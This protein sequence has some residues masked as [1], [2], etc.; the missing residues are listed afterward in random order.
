MAGTMV[1]LLV[2]EK[3]LKELQRRNWRYPD[4]EES[5]F[6]PDYFIAG[7]IC[8]DGIMACKNYER[9]MKLHT[10]FRDGIPDGSF[11]KPGMVQL[12]EKR[13]RQFWEE[14]K[15]EDRDFLSLYLGYITH[16]M[17]DERFIL[18][19][20]PKFFE[21][22]AVIHLTQQD[23]ET[24]IRFNCETDLVDFRLIRE[25]PILQE[26]KKALERVKPYEIRGMIMAE[27]LNESRA[28][29]L[30]HFFREQHQKEQTQYLEYDRMVRFVET[31]TQEIINRLFEEHY[32]EE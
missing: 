28:W 13:M 23:R 20:R 18:E 14:H 2:A 19:E 3:L 32:L 22:I 30:Q 4:V 16:M 31:V 26:A 11:D 9:S 25:F 24:F 15:R 5:V 8:P 10:H 17:T 27:E 6:E 12:F 21:N 7:N 1:H 29:I